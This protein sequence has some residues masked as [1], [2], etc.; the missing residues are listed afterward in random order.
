MTKRAP[1]RTFLMVVGIFLIIGG[2][3]AMVTKR[4][5]FCNDRT[6]RICTDFG[7]DFAAGWN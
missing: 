4:H 1:G 3:S 5:E 6:G 7:T 2:V